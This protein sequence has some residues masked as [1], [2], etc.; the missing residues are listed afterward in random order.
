MHLKTISVYREHFHEG[1]GQAVE[2]FRELFKND[3]KLALKIP[4]LSL[5]TDIYKRIL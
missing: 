2:V 5:A 3:R 1:F 4:D